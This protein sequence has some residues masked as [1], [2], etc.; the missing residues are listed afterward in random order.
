[1]IDEKAT[2]TPVSRSTSSL[3]FLLSEPDKSGEEFWVL[4]NP[5]QYKSGGI[6][7]ESWVDTKVGKAT[8]VKPKPPKVDKPDTKK[9]GKQVKDQPTSDKISTVVD[10]PK[11]KPKP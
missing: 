3:A 6:R 4:F 7:V 1:M 5:A 2:I 8:L 9:D 10:A 11:D